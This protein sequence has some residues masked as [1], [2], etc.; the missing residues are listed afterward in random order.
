[1]NVQHCVGR[2]TYMYMYMYTCSYTPKKSYACMCMM[3]NHVKGYLATDIIYQFSSCTT[4]RACF[5]LAQLQIHVQCMYMYEQSLQEM[6]KKQ[7]LFFKATTIKK[8]TERQSNT[9]HPKQLFFL[10][11]L[12]VHVCTYIHVHVHV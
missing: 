5:H 8:T 7:L 1:M 10:R 12:V 9:T 3:T 2:P 11:K 4:T 6:V